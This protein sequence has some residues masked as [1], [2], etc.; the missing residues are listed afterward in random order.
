[1]LPSGMAV[2]KHSFFRERL[3]YTRLILARI[4]PGIDYSNDALFI[5]FTGVL[6]T[7]TLS[8]PSDEKGIPI[9]PVFHQLNGAPVA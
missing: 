3:K 6:S 9:P 2:G 1:M 4:C 5:L 7:F 8:A